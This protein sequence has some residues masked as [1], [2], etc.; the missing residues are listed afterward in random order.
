MKLRL[1]SVSSCVERV[2]RPERPERPERLALDGRCLTPGLSVSVVVWR[3]GPT[4][5]CLFHTDS[6]FTASHPALSCP[7]C[8]CPRRDIVPPQSHPHPA[9]E[10][11]CCNENP[12]PADSAPFCAATATVSRIKSGQDSSVNHGAPPPFPTSITD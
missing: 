3:P 2:A 10:I 8:T 7:P 4:C 5:A 6:G 1:R 9:Q 11:P 12:D